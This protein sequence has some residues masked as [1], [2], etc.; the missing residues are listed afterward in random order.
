MSFELTSTAFANSDPIPMKYT[1][2]DQD[3]SP[4]LQ[5]ARFGMRLG[6]V[7]LEEPILR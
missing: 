7:D 4:P 6:E 2:D 3:I 5:E 1:C